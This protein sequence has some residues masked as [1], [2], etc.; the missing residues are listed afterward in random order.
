MTDFEIATVVYS[1]ELNLIRL[2]A[3]SFA[4]YLDLNHVKKVWV[5]AN[6][7]ENECCIAQLRSIY[8][9]QFG[10]D[11]SLVEIVPREAIISTP[12]GANGYFTQQLLKMQICNFVSTTYFVVFDAKNFLIGPAS[13]DY[14]FNNGKPKCTL[15]TYE[16]FQKSIKDRYCDLFRLGPERR[17]QPS[18]SMMTPFVFYTDLVKASIELYQDVTRKSIADLILLE[19]SNFY[20]VSE[21]LLYDVAL[22]A[23]N[24]RIEELYF[25]IAQLSLTLWE[26]NYP[27]EEG[28][29]A[30]FAVADASAVPVLGLHRKRLLEMSHGE[31]EVLNKLLSKRG[32]GPLLK[33]S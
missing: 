3:Q 24:R 13:T 5:I 27:S 25:P 17:N 28:L 8:F 10:F 1:Q 2:Q 9:E 12:H 32:L 20:H 19:L 23:M 18:L 15:S 31:W 29:S 33:I 14:F 11:P 30:A 7:P 21:F 22:S 16:G 4:R 26:G 6:D